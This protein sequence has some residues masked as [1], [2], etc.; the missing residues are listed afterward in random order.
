MSLCPRP[1]AGKD[2]LK[3]RKQWQTGTGNVILLAGGSRLVA[4][5]MLKQAKGAVVNVAS[6]AALDHATGTSAYAA[7]KAAAW[8]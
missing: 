7:A 1:S 2:R 6:R 8:R 4:P 5:V 3:V